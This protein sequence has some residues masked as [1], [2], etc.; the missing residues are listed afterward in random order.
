LHALDARESAL[1]SLAFGRD[2]ALLVAG[3]E[4][5]E[6]SV[7]DAASGRLVRA[8]TQDESPVNALAFDVKGRGTLFAG[9]ESSHLTILDLAGGQAH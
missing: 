2:G 8:V 7:W 4:N 9:S 3:A 5:G 1:R 6:I